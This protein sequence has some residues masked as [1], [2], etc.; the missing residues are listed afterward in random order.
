MNVNQAPNQPGT[1]SGDIASCT[2]D[3]S[4]YSVS[5]VAG[6]TSYTWTLPNGWTG[7]STT[8]SI[9]VTASNNGGTIS[10]T[11]NNTCGSSTAQTLSVSVNQ[12]PNQ[13]G[14]ISGDVT[15][16][17]G[18]ESTFF[19]AEVNGATS[20]TWTLPNGWIGSSSSA[21]IDVTAGANGGEITVTANNNCGSSTAQSLNV[22]VDSAPAQ[23][24]AIN[25]DIALCE[26]DENTFSVAEVNGATSYTWTLPNGWTGS[27]STA[28]IDATA[29]DNGG[30]I[31]VTVNNNCG[32]SDASEQSVV[33]NPLPVVTFELDSNII[34]N[35]FG[36]FALTG[37]LPEGGNYSGTGVS[38]NVFSPSEAGPGVHIITYTYTDENE[39]SQSAEQEITVE[40]CTGIDN[41]SNETVLIYPNPF[42]NLLVL[43]FEE[44]RARLIEFHN[45]VGQIVHTLRGKGLRMTVDAE[46][47]AP[48]IYFIRISG[49]EKVYRV[50]RS[51]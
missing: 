26:G 39:C 31:T 18:D 10:V 40:V 30:E 17:D 28:S 8:N 36:D 42:R 12:A 41:Q 19:V 5:A 43:E 34:C 13:P 1:I 37:G 16:C 32:S 9:D 7:N 27:S 6:A 15:L 22:S 45:A 21:S 44:S 29:G 49:E 48:G 50:V 11:A 25:G 33:S 3:Q 47:L 14:A 4:T 23:P 2:G 35:N 51:H 20:Y 46:H 38:D 24:G